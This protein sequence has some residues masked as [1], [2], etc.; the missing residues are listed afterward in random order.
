VNANSDD[1]VIEINNF[2]VEANVSVH[3]EKLY[4]W[5]DLLYGTEEQISVYKIKKHFF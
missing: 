1:R 5:T 2:T 3:S 4:Q